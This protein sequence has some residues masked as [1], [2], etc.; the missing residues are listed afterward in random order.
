VEEGISATVVTNME[1]SAESTSPPPPTESPV[2]SVTP[3]IPAGVAGASWEPKGLRWIAAG[4]GIGFAA[5]VTAF[6]VPT[7]L[8]L[9]ATYNP[10]I[11]LSFGPT[12]IKATGL[13]A[14]AGAALFAISLLAFRMGFGGFRKFE[15]RFWTATILCTVGTV[16]WVLLILPAALALVS[17]DSL[18]LCVQGAPTHSLTCIQSVA[19]LAGYVAVI[20]FW[21]VWVGEVGIVVGLTLTSR[22]FR[23][24]A[25]YA[26]TVLYG[27]LL[28]VFIAPFLGLLF[29]SSPL[30]Y[31]ILAV[32]LLG[33]MAPAFVAY[34]SGA[35]RARIQAS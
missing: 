22:R 31:A 11:L 9:L 8:V 15:R 24:S 20:A 21:L 1:Q 17:S 27:L 3:E 25:I 2:A 23:N 18:Y 14:A 19:P 32:A 34:G 4:A 7:A 6:A 26:G 16:G 30:T 33:L 5:A 12:L 35:A 13:F 10:A 28:L 29:A